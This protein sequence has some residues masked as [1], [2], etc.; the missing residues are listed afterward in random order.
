MGINLIAA[1]WGI[2]EA[3]LFFIVPDVW[4]SI[5]GRTRLQRGLLACLYALGGAIV[6]GIVMYLW[7][8][9]DLSGALGI[10]ELIPA[11]STDMISRVHHRLAQ[12]GVGAVLWGPLSG[13]PYKVYAVQASDTGIGLGLF[14]LVTI[15]AR[16]IRFFLVT[17]LC[18]YALRYLS[19]YRFGQNRLAVLILGWV[20]FYWAYFSAMP[21]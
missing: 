16:L 10:V 18:H 21:G 13:T 8:R 19:R 3:T 1:L 4:L 5:L 2:S 15:P 17:A 9:Q 6:G 11:I 7:G 14:V 12:E 20:L